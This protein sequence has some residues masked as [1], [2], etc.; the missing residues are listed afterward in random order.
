VTYSGVTSVSL[1]GVFSATY[2]NYAVVMSVTTV[3]VANPELRYRAAGT[4]S[5]G[6]N[7]VEQFLRAVNTTV[8]GLLRT[9][10]GHEIILLGLN[11]S[12]EG[13]IYSPFEAAPT[14]NFFNMNSETGIASL[15][16]RNTLSTSFDGFT[17]TNLAASTFS[18]VIRVYGL[19]N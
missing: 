2:Q 18:G 1:N 10:T 5:T 8:S 14:A 11:N 7:Y 9:R 16:C 12:Y 13:T 6:S 17:L 3:G 4:D 15:T 19:Q